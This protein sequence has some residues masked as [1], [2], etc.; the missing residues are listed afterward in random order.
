MLPVEGRCQPTLARRTTRARRKACTT[1]LY[2]GGRVPKD[3]IRIQLNGA[4]D[5]AQALIGLA[6]AEL[7]PGSETDKLLVQIARHLYVLMAEVATAP[8]NRRKLVAGS[9]L[10]TDEMV[11]WVE[12]RIDDLTRSVKIPTDFVIPGD[13]RRS[14]TF[15]LARTVVRRAER[16][17]VD[18]PDHDSVVGRYLDRL[19]DLLW[20]M[21]RA[22]EDDEDVRVLARDRLPRQSRRRASR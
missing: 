19:S 18:L 5:E 2:F 11:R 14:A 9:T 21:A 6:R 20:V 12:D 7:D 8:E 4:V 10:V 15:D 13:N 22:Q 17:M 3:S 1:G 16:V